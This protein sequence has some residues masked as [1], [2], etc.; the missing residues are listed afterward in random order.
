M[1]RLL[2]RASRRFLA[3]HP[4][5]YALA[6][7]GVAL[8]VAVVLGVDLA[9]AS[10]R[11]SFDASREMVTGRATHQV[12]PLG[13]TLDERLYVRLRLELGVDTAAPA[14]EGGIGLPGGR[15]ATLLGVD[16]LAEAPFRPELAAGSQDVDVAA[17]LVRPGAVALPGSLARELRLAV[18][19]DL[20]IEGP[21]GARTLVVVGLIEPEPARRAALEGY[22]VADISTAQEALGL[23]GRLSRIDLVLTDAEAKRLAASLPQDVEL[24]EA[25][26]RSAASYGMTRAFRLNL[27]AL[28]LLALLVG[29]FLIYST[30]AFLVVR[31]TR[32]IGILR[33]LGVERAGIARSVL[34]EALWVGIP[35][36]LAGLALGALLGSGLTTLVVRTIDDLYFRLRVDALAL[37]PWPF[38]KAALLGIGAT[39]AAALGPALEA[40]RIPPRAVLSR[41]SMERR[42]RRR[43][44]RQLAAAAVSLVAAAALLAA[45]DDSLLVSFAGLFAVFIAAALSTTPATAG[46]MAALE[47]LM[48]RNAPLSL[49]MA[50]RGSAASLSRTG[51]AVSALAVAVATV[52]G[53][54]LMVASFRGSVEHWLGHSLVADFYLYPDAAWCRAAGGVD[55]MAHTLQALPMV[56]GVSFSQRRRLPAPDEE[57]R[58]WAIDPGPG[59]LRVEIVAG[60]APRAQARF[61]AGE[62]VL[63]SEPWVRRRGTGVGDVVTL[64]TPA[65]PRR[66]PV[67]AV[68]RD[69]TSDRGVVALHRNAYRA[70]WKDDCVEG[71]GVSLTPDAERAAARAAIEAQVP[72]G[73]GTRIAANAELRAASLAVFDR[74]FTITRV[75]QLLVGIVAFLGVLAALQALQLERV[76]ETAVLR[77]VGWLPRQLRALIAA[78]TGLLGFAAGL[79][80]IPVGIALAALLV[81]VINRRAFGWS[82][83]FELAP[84]ELAQGM[85]LALAAALLAGVAPAWRATRRPVAEDLRED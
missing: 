79:F 42:T 45:G 83:Q 58:L 31:R 23:L 44:P 38:A 80:S 54:G 85:A 82:M 11:R 66:Y 37:V 40:A 63:V 21:G 19:N 14:L 68:F 16:P 9:G 59:G 72:P 81:F 3:R 53:V 28:S 12:L 65:G 57:I 1:S 32:T 17:L 77:A 4:W 7:A 74:T 2:G 29:A 5:Q 55:A 13:T 51:V 56:A 8:G 20:P 67:V 61:A 34:A 22:V 47:R 43:M 27:T 76:R 71:M 60:D 35:G 48:P 15:R 49:S 64:P 41:A 24:V 75:L 6:V 84:A 78:Q 69:Y 26:A 25:A 30:L 46:L 33:S 52:I 39:T 73:S 10:A 70:L 18:G 36:T 62:A 50:I